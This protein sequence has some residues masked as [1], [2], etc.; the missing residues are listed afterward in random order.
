MKRI[1]SLLL[2]VILVITLSATVLTSCDKKY[3]EDEVR[4]AAK[5]LIE[6]SI[7][8]NEIYWGEG[9]PYNVG[10]KNNSDGVYYAAIEA[11]HYQWGFKTID[12]LRALT[13]KTFSKG[14][15][16]NI[17]TTMLTGIVEGGENVFL[18]RYYQK[19][20]SLDGTPEFIMVNSD[21]EVELIGRVTY[22]YDSIKVIGSEDETVYVTVMA[23]VTE[24][25]YDPQT[26][27]I[28]IALVEE[29][30]GWKIDSPTYLNYDKTNLNNK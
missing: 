25:G 28:R 17:E 29:S 5:R 8:L 19:I 18:S 14:Y 15:C 2:T 16:Q 26:R 6:E 12:E 3:D 20:S 7:L 21:W 10:D 24:E 13:A 9:I 1:I 27:E 22:D 23:T 11:Y 4:E 30:D